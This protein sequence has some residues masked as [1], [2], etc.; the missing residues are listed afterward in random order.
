MSSVPGVATSVNGVPIRLA[1]ARWQHILE[2]HDDL[3][4]YDQDVLQVI[5]R[6]EGVFEGRNGSLIAVRRYGRRGL[7]AVF[8][9][10]VSRDD[11]F[12]ITARFLGSQPRS[13]KIWPKH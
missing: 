5:E 11:G 9:R 1:E 4:N 13:Q 8:Y 3:F 12:V 10:E 2:G 6:P 7:L